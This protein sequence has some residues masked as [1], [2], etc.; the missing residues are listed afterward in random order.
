MD[1]KTWF[2]MGRDD[3][4]KNGLACIEELAR[5]EMLNVVVVGGRDENTCRCPQAD[6]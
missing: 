1:D 3:L 6:R 5:R 4:L 2:N